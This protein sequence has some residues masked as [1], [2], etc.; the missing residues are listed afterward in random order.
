MA[1]PTTFFTV[2]HRRRDQRTTD[3]SGRQAGRFEV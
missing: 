1:E 2:G 3:A